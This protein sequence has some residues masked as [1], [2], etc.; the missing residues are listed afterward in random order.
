V[1][2]AIPLISDNRAT[3]LEVSNVPI[4]LQKAKNFRLRFSRQKTKQAEIDD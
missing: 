4:V 3:L 2:S 1:T